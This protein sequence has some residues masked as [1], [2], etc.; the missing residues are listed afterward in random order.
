MFQVILKRQAEKGLK[1]LHSKDQKKVVVTLHLLSQNH[2]DPSLNIK[3]LKGYPKLEHAFRLRIGQLR[4]I[5]EITTN[6]KVIIVYF[7]GYRQTTT[8]S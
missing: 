7:I 4:V 3:K 2:R 6:K 8:Y 5:Y 1:H